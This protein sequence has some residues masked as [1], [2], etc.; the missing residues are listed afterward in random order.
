MS[1][2][3]TVKLKWSKSPFLGGCTCSTRVVIYVYCT[4]PPSSPRNASII[5]STG[6]TRIRIANGGPR[7]VGS[8]TTTMPLIIGWFPV[9]CQT[10]RMRAKRKRLSASVITIFSLIYLLIASDGGRAPHPRRPRH[11]TRSVLLHQLLDN[12]Q[13]SHLPYFLASTTSHGRPRGQYWQLNI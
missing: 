9:H 12:C 5:F 13:L 4:R 3:G 6:G 11:S 8:I 1:R 2:Q 7:R 10:F